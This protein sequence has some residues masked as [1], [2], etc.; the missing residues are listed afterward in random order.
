MFCKIDRLL[1]CETRRFDDGAQKDEAQQLSDV[2]VLQQ[3]PQDIPEKLNHPVVWSSDESLEE[4]KA[5]QEER[6]VLRHRCR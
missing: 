3:F 5:L 1:A 6:A 4:S 2:L